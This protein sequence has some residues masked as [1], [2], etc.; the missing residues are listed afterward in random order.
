MALLDTA[1]NFLQGGLGFGGFE[2]FKSDAPALTISQEDAGASAENGQGITFSGPRA[3]VLRGRAL[4]NSPLEI[5]GEQRRKTT[6]YPGNP[7]A[8]IQVLGTTFGTTT[9]SGV[10]KYRFIGDP[11]YEAYEL[12]GFG[13]LS[14]N[15]A[16][17]SS[18]GAASR[19]PQQLVEAFEKL[20][21]EGKTV[22]VEWN[23]QQRRG[24]IS[25]FTA[26]WQRSQ[27]VEWT[28]EF[29]WFAAGPDRPRAQNLALPDE[30][31]VTWSSLLDDILALE[32]RFL[33]PDV[34]AI[35]T[36]R[37][38]RVRQG[39]STVFD[40]V[41]FNNTQ[42]RSPLFA[43]QAINT[44]NFDIRVNAE[45]VMSRVLDRPYTESSPRDDVI[46]VLAVEQ[47]NRTV[48]QRSGELRAA[49]LN[50]GKSINE[51]N[52][53]GALQVVVVPQDTTLRKLSQVYYG[54]ADDW[55][56]IADINFLNESQVEA[57][58]TLIIPQKPA[59][60]DANSPASTRNTAEQV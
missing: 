33:F 25:S 14:F 37:I 28:C 43:L 44:A 11:T 48:G 49:A 51:Q 3:I 9:I 10:W 24:I 5:S 7:Q 27:D 40:F 20:R 2:G 53:P 13:D 39:V 15:A 29:E 54:T 32:P 50:A 52:A 6:Y 26:R 16:I 18:E 36:E 30:P 17:A 57:G 31:V 4:P 56:L 19:T 22:L 41:R 38:D 47:Y 42:V 59:Q 34:V 12:N 58:T 1:Q 60:R 23:D 46:G 45:E 55:Q 21:D 35:V 8:T